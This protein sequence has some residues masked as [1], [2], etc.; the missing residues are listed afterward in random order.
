MGK[1]KFKLIGALICVS[2]VATILFSV[3][4]SAA[5]ENNIRTYEG[6]LLEGHCYAPFGGEPYVKLIFED[7]R[8]FT[9]PEQLAI[10]AEMKIGETYQISYNIQEPNV[11]TSIKRVETS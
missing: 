1:M 7:G 9:A 10:E 4:S 5:P 2:V 6:T 8:T 11:A 3:G